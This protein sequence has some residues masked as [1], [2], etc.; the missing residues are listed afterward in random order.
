M[1][2]IEP[3]SRLTDGATVASWNCGSVT[4]AGSRFAA[5]TPMAAPTAPMTS[6][7]TSNPISADGRSLRSNSACRKENRSAG[8]NSG[9]GDASGAS[10]GGPSRAPAVGSDHGSAGGAPGSESVFAAGGRGRLSWDPGGRPKASSRYSGTGVDPSGTGP[11]GLR[12][13]NDPPTPPGRPNA[14]ACSGSTGGFHSGFGA[15]RG[16][17][18]RDAVA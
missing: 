14:P 4:L 1:S 16:R 7:D 17:P 8:C 15:S 6:A 11:F 18:L 10:A 12:G 2:A 5:N 13:A 9:D 3:G